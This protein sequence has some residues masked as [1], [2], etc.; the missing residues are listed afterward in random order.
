MSPWNGAAPEALPARAAA[1]A[2]AAIEQARVADSARIEQLSPAEL[3]RIPVT[4]P[5]LTTDSG[6]PLT[7]SRGLRHRAPLARAAG[8]PAADRVSPHA[9][10]SMRY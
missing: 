4:G 10:T 9:H 3:A 8:L 6:R 7:P 1:A 2:V 5:L